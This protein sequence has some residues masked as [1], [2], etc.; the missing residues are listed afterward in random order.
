MTINKKFSNMAS[1]ESL[2]IVINSLKEKGINV[3]VEDSGA[4]A[5]KKFFDIVPYGSEIM[6]M[7]SV[8]LNQIGLEKEIQESGNYHTVRQEFKKYDPKKDKL[9]MKRLG[10]VHQ[11]AVGSVH[12]ITETGTIL[13]AS[14]T[15]SQLPSYAYGAD[16]ILWIVGTQKIVE[17][18]KEGLDRLYEYCLPLENERAMRA[19]GKPSAVNKILIINQEVVPGRLNIIFVKEKLGF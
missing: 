1:S 6:N 10:S 11:W 13:F 2:N 5:K 12:A 16:N 7:T 18:I 4:A 9:K 19:Y 8:T 17:N 14:A 3:F 15:G